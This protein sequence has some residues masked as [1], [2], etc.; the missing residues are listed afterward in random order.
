MAW[1]VRRCSRESSV[2]GPRGIKVRA[3][4]HGCPAP[5]MQVRRQ[6]WRTAVMPLRNEARLAPGSQ[7]EC[8]SSPASAPRKR[9]SMHHGVAAFARL[10][11]VAQR[12]RRVDLWAA[13]RHSAGGIFLSRWLP[14]CGRRPALREPMASKK[15]SC[16]DILQLFHG[17]SR[18]PKQDTD[19]RHF[20]SMA[21]G[22]LTGRLQVRIRFYHGGPAFT[23]RSK[24]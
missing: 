6:G 11:H 13:R 16:W 10:P 3:W 21:R 15:S 5:R 8:L 1:A 14:I 23:Q 20:S 17:V 18:A 12:R 4:R 22:L 24:R 7:K 9:G 19:S 2:A